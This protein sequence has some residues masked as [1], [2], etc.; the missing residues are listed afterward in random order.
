MRPPTGESQSKSEPE[1]TVNPAREKFYRVLR[2]IQSHPFVTEDTL[3]FR[4][5]LGQLMAPAKEELAKIGVTEVVFVPVG[6]VATGLVQKGESDIDGIIFYSCS[7]ELAPTVRKVLWRNID[8]QQEQGP[9][10]LGISLQRIEDAI[11]SPAKTHSSLP[12]VSTSILIKKSGRLS[13]GGAED[14]CS[15]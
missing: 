13:T 6:S 3:E 15:S 2:E 14:V 10:D 11:S 12:P 4:Q 1:E 7:I 9:P 5:K 8:R